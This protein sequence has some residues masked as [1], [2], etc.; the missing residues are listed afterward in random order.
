MPILPI[1][2]QAKD[3][4]P[5]SAK[6]NAASDAPATFIVSSSVWSQQANQPIG[7][8]LELDG[9]PIGSATIWS[10]GTATHRAVVLAYIP[11]TLTFGTHTVTLL[12][13]NS[14]T[15]SGLNDSFNLVFDY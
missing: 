8:T 2:S 7:V 9:K 15:V 5:V 13:T 12:P 1:I 6:F 3:P 10:N 4:L 14:S 11:V